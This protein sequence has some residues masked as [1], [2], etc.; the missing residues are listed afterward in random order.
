MANFSTYVFNNKI[1]E[2]RRKCS[3]EDWAARMKGPVKG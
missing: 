3:Q 2:K 1:K